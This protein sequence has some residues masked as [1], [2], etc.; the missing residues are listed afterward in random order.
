MK[1]L[2]FT[3]CKPILMS[4]SKGENTLVGNFFEPLSSK[5]YLVNAGI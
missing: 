1:I 3:D 5:Q 4:Y 2:L